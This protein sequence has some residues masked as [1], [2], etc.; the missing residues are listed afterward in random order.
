MAKSTYKGRGYGKGY[1]VSKILETF[2][3]MPEYRRGFKTEALWEG[4]QVRRELGNPAKRI[5][6]R[7]LVD[8]LKK[9]RGFGYDKIETFFRNIS[10]AKTPIPKPA[11]KSKLPFDKEKPQLPTKEKPAEWMKEVGRQRIIFEQGRKTTPY[12][13]QRFKELPTKADKRGLF[14]PE[15]KQPLRQT[16]KTHQE[17]VREEKEKLAEHQKTQEQNIQKSQELDKKETEEE[18]RVSEVM[19]EE[20]GPSA[21]M[22]KEE[23]GGGEKTS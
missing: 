19:K 15:I 3:K 23:T 4:G 10:P 2:K 11:E 5:S 21:G 7:K 12:S 13:R 1:K 6:G 16:P 18:G 8:Y 14:L 17:I 20:F 9:K 22:D